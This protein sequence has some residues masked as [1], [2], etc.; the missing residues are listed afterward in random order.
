MAI[1]AFS[2]CA[3]P[4]AR[5]YEHQAQKECRR[6]NQKKQNTRVWVADKSPK[7]Y[8]QQKQPQDARRRDEHHATQAQSIIGKMKKRRSDEPQAATGPGSIIHECD[9]ILR[10]VLDFFERE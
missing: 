2:A 7:I 8:R 6:Q 1:P 10:S 9:F 5:R 4:D 3:Q